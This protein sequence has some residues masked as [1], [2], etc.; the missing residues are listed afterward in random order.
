MSPGSA[1][2]GTPQSWFSLCQ[3]PIMNRN[4]HWKSWCKMTHPVLKI[5]CNKNYPGKRP[6]T[7][8]LRTCRAKPRGEK[9]KRKHASSGFFR[10]GHGTE[11]CSRSFYSQR[12][13]SV[14]VAMRDAAAAAGQLAAAAEGQ[15]VAGLSRCRGHGSGCVRSIRF[16][17]AG[18][19]SVPGR[20]LVRWPN[21]AT[22]VLLN[23]CA[24]ATTSSPASRSLL[25]RPLDKIS[26]RD[27]SAR[28]LY[29]I[30]VQALYKSSLGKSYVRDRLARSL[31]HLSM[32]CLCARSL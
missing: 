5:N 13:A 30:S 21:A 12:G 17:Q 26:I 7:V 29:E 4:C 32:Q 23:V 3:L 25:A 11:L 31:Q 27:I 1:N 18:E 2:Y 16:C 14:W 10:C 19:H 22:R 20:G 15:T 28:S 8:C 6:Q 9:Q 24:P